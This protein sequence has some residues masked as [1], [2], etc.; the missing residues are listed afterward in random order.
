MAADKC[1]P[2]PLGPEVRSRLEIDRQWYRLGNRWRRIDHNDLPPPGRDREVDT[3]HS[4]DRRGPRAHSVDDTA[5]LVTRGI[6]SA[7]RLEV[8]AHDAVVF[9]MKIHDSRLRANI[10]V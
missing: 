4:A 7:D 1:H 3:R 2:V 10:D 6:L 5:N 8:G 9:P